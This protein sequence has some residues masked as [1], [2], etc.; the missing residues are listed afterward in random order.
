MAKITSFRFIID[1]Q[2]IDVPIKADSSGRFTCE[3]PEIIATSL[4]LETS[5]TAEMTLK[6]LRDRLNAIAYQWANS[7]EIITRLIFV[8]AST[9]GCY[10]P[11]GPYRDSDFTFE[12]GVGTV[13]RAT[14]VDRKERPRQARPNYEFV[15]SSIPS[16]AQPGRDEFYGT[17]CGHFIPWTQQAEDHIARVVVKLM[18]IANTVYLITNTKEG[19][20][21]M[22]TGCLDTRTVKLLEKGKG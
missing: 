14:V 22:I 5:Y 7:T 13:F 15:D 3:V 2:S 12:R 17:L 6:A 19:L 4:G 9:S 18:E 11:Y 16:C 8:A 20:E 10:P 21:A 1:G